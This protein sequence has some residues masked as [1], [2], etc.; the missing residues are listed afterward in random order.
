MERWDK[1]KPGTK[2]GCCQLN[3]WLNRKSKQKSFHIFKNLAVLRAEVIAI[4]SRSLVI[5]LSSAAGHYYNTNVASS[6]NRTVYCSSIVIHCYQMHI[7]NRQS[8][9]LRC[10][11]IESVRPLCYVACVWPTLVGPAHQFCLRLMRKSLMPAEMNTKFFFYSLSLSL[12]VV[13][14]CSACRAS[15]T[16]RQ[17][18]VTRSTNV[19]ELNYHHSCVNM[20]V[21]PFIII[22]IISGKRIFCCGRQST[23]IL[24]M[25]HSNCTAHC[26]RYKQRITTHTILITVLKC[27]NGII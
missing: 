22:I 2:S 10:A 20:S 17:D 26:R 19:Y 5:Q 24:R 25:L 6:H 7:N 1:W 23:K 9:Y 13:F 21:I 12:S 18:T 4:I 3:S 15:C 16:F 11:H 8:S 14:V 27:D